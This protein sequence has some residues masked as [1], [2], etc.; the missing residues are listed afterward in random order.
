MKGKLFLVLLLCMMV[1]CGG[2]NKPASSSSDEVTYSPT[3]YTLTYYVAW[4]VDKVARGEPFTTD[5]LIESGSLLFTQN[6]IVKAIEFSSGWKK[7]NHFT[8]RTAVPN[9]WWLYMIYYDDIITKGCEVDVYIPM[10]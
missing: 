7:V 6:G 5:D 3:D 1:A 8:K 2:N 4:N 9:K 10:K